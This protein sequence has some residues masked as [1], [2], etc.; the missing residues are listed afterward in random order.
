MKQTLAIA[1]LAFFAIGCGGGKW[2]P[3]EEQQYLNKCQTE[4]I[5]SS[6]EKCECKL[7]YFK[8]NGIGFKSVD[9]AKDAE[10]SLSLDCISVR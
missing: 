5:S 6:K 7:K 9:D 3:E 1:S 2:T 10:A 8:D 4:G